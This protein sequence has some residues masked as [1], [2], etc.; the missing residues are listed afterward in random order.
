MDTDLTIFENF[1]IRRHFD[2]KQEKWFFSITDLIAALIDQQDH[3]KAKSYWSTLKNRLKEEGSEVVTNCD[4]LKN[5][6]NSKTST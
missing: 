1:K 5:K 3:K 4:H 6:K 2:K